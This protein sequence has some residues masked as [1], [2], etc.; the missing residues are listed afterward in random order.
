MLGYDPVSHSEPNCHGEKYLIEV[1]IG[2]PPSLI[3]L[4]HHRLADSGAG[5]AEKTKLHIL[6]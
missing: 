4:P 5:L 2:T 1:D 6:N 3:R